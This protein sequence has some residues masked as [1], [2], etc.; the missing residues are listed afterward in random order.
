ML[1]KK[2]RFRKSG[3][4][5][6]NSLYRFHNFFGGLKFLQ[7]DK[8]KVFEIRNKVIRDSK[9][10]TQVANAWTCGKA[11]D[12]R[13]PPIPWAGPQR[14]SIWRYSQ[15][16]VGRPHSASC[17]ALSPE[18]LS[19]PLI[20]SC[21]CETLAIWP[22]SLHE[23]LGIEV[24]KDLSPRV[25]SFCG[26]AEKTT[27]CSKL[28]MLRAKSWPVVKRLCAQQTLPRTTLQTGTRQSNIA[29]CSEQTKPSL[30]IRQSP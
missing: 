9:K 2:L 27:E 10:K 16:D 25:R 19:T 18:L 24:N 12:N 22:S 29:N 15:N 14:P 5:I 1:Y 3:L 28:S 21:L 26:L 30:V 13:S 4:K 7:K 11:G 8:L 23:S 6:Q 20:S 17:V